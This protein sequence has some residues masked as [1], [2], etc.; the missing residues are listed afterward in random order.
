MNHSRRWASVYQDLIATLKSGILGDVKDIHYTCGGGRL[1]SN[2]THFFDLARFVLGGDAVSVIGQLD[3]V[4]A[5]DPR[6][7]A[8]NDPGGVAQVRFASGAVLTVDMAGDLGVPP[9]LNIT[10][11]DGRVLVDETS[12]ICKVYSRSAEHRSKPAH[13]RYVVPLTSTES[14]F[15]PLYPETMLRAAIQNLLSSV[16]PMCS[17]ADGRAALEIAVAANHSHETG[18]AAVQLPLPTAQ[19]S[20]TFRWA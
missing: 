14:I 12:G 16:P 18:G 17:G 4:V 8:F 5:E 9:F 19:R 20:R 10:C 6:G 1:G 7:M 13:A 11:T 2:G 15:T 3:E